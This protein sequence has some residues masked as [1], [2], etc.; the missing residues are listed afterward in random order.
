MEPRTLCLP[1]NFHGYDASANANQARRSYQQALVFAL[2]MG[3]RPLQAQCH[4]VLGELAEKAG[5]TQGVRDHLTTALSMFCEMSMQFW[6]D[7]IDVA[8]KR[9]S[10]P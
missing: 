6:L 3:L 5:E 1:S 9:L 2:D 8:L 4:C 10:A 7:N